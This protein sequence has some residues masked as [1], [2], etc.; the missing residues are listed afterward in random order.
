M[1]IRDSWESLDET[2]RHAAA[3][4]GLDYVTNDDS[5]SRPFGAPPVV[6]NYFYHEKIR[7]GGECYAGTS[8]G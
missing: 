8:R 5:M 4:L 6:V 7:K 2:L 3:S 1:C